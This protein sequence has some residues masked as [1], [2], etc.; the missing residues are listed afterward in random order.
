MEWF[1]ET[2]FDQGPFKYYN[3]KFVYLGDDQPLDTQ[4]KI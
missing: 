1:H 3:T 2:R 4:G